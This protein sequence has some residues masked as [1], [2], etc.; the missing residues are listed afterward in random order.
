MSHL[1]HLSYL[2]DLPELEFVKQVGYFPSPCGAESLWSLLDEMA[3]LKHC[4][5]WPGGD[6]LSRELAVDRFRYFVVENSTVLALL[7]EP[8]GNDQDPQPTVTVLIRGPFGRHAWTMQLRHLPR[9]KSG[10]KYHA[11]NPGRPVPMAD[12]GV[13]HDVKH[14]YFPEN[15]DRIPT[16][17][18]DKSIPSLESLLAEA[19]AGAAAENAHL[20][21]LVEQQAT[22]EAAA[23]QKLCKETDGPFPEC[24]PPTPCHEFQTA[25]LFLSHFGFL[26]AD[27]TNGN[28][29]NALIALDTSMEG[30]CRELEALDS[31]SSRT[32]DTVH[33]FYVRAGQKTAEEIL[34]NVICPAALYIIFPDLDMMSVQV[35]TRTEHTCDVTKCSSRFRRYAF[36]LCRVV[37]LILH[38]W[39]YAEFS[40]KG[41]R[42]QYVKKYCQMELNFSIQY[43]T[44]VNNHGGSLYNGDMKVLYW[45][46]ASSEIAFVVPTRCIDPEPQPQVELSADSSHPSGQGWFER[47]V[48]DSA[49]SSRAG[50]KP[51]TL[52]LD[53]D[54]SST[55]SPG[56]TNGSG[57]RRTGAI[58]HPPPMHSNTKVLV[59]WTESFEDQLQLPLT[60]LLQATMT[61]LEGNTGRPP[62]ERDCFVICLHALASGLLRVKLQGPAGGRTSLATPLVDGMVVSRRALGSLVRQT[63]LNM[64]RR[65]RLDNDS[66]QP[67]HVRRRLKVQDLVQKYRCELSHPELLTYLF[68]DPPT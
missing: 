64:C 53:L 58:R 1:L 57:R 33:V 59:F 66:Y 17:K 20:F 56:S 15:V 19:G 5:S 51:R 39:G 12:V 54:K 62:D 4:N 49:S 30:F 61:G 10:T 25:R 63:A 68:S 42:N 21:Q 43:A 31:I 52:S 44:S 13:R 65:R 34:S 28:V 60:D 24:T 40:D 27:A 41:G 23:G 37:P 38:F 16:C 36:P 9:H 50:E 8:L 22:M 6:N 26:S 7:E 11:P 55:S 18:V 3:L 67:P 48:S 29:G 47:S 46:D 2:L 45:A 35:R 32:C 14:R